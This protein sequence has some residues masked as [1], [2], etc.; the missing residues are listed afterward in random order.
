MLILT[1]LLFLLVLALSSCFSTDGDVTIIQTFFSSG[2]FFSSTASSATNTSLYHLLFISCSI[3]ALCLCPSFSSAGTQ[4]IFS[5][6]LLLHTYPS[7]SMALLASRGSQFEFFIYLPT[8]R[9]LPH[10]PIETSHGQRV[11]CP[12]SPLMLLLLPLVDQSVVVV[13]Y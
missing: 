1:L 5:T 8:L 7:Q 3:W 10:S 11:Q 6:V 4:F 13:L 9:A 12:I 2:L